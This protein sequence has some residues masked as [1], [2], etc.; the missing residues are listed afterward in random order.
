M[1]RDEG[2]RGSEEDWMAALQAEG[3]DRG[4]QRESQA[5]GLDH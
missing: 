5:E 2:A 3:G 1:E 4:G